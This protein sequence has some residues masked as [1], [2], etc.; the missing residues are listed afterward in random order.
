MNAPRDS[1][2]LTNFRDSKWRYSQFVVLGVITCVLVKW[3]SSLAWLPALL[4]GSAVA[5]AYYLLEKR[6]GVI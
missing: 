3:L 4:I 2:P 1:A 5:A 6:R